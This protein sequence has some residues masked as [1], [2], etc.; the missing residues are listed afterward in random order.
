MRIRSR[1]L[2]FLF[3]AVL[4]VPLG[5]STYDGARTNG[6]GLFASI[7]LASPPFL[8]VL[9]LPFMHR[10]GI[11]WLVIAV[12]AMAV[13]SLVYSEFVAPVALL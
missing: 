5:W 8:V 12:M 3:A 11:R 4:L 9:A 2:L 1:Y 13:I 10:I 7:C 6:Y